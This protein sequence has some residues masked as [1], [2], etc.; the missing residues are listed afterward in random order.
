MVYYHLSAEQLHH[1][2]RRSAQINANANAQTSSSGSTTMAP[3]QSLPGP[4]PQS[5]SQSTLPNHTSPSASAAEESPSN[6][7]VGPSPHSA[8]SSSA[9]PLEIPS[10]IMGLISTS[11]TQSSRASTNLLNSRHHLPLS[12]LRS[13][14][15]VTYDTAIHSELADESLPPPN[16]PLGAARKVDIDHLERFVWPIELGMC[17][18][19]AHLAIFGRGLI[20]E[21]AETAGKEWETN[22][23]AGA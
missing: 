8:S 16:D 17:A 20:R 15:P 6:P 19:M 1:L 5:Q 7:S 18:P 9:H 23:E 2:N 22:L 3:S 14:F 13:K 12:L 4:T 11:T 21:V 10:E